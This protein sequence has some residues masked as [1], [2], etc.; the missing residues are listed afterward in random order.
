MAEVAVGLRV[1]PTDIDVDLD[2]LAEKITLA[3]PKYAKLCGKTKKD[4]AFG[5]KCLDM[6]I[7]IPD[8]SG[9][10]EKIEQIIC[11]IDEVESVE[12]IG[13]TLV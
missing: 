3:L 2:K 10:S 4:I 12:I 6:V 13:T 7:I 8:A 9:G 11:A 5:L 1:M